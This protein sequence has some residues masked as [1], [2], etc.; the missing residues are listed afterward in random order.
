MIGKDLYITCRKIRK[1]QK[2]VLGNFVLVW[3]MTHSEIPGQ[4]VNTIP[5]SLKNTDSQSRGHS[6]RIPCSH[7]YLIEPGGKHS[8]IARWGYWLQLFHHECR[9][10][11][12]KSRNMETWMRWGPLCFRGA[13]IL[14]ERFWSNEEIPVGSNLM[15]GIRWL[16]SWRM[17]FEGSYTESCRI[18]PFC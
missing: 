4:N 11:R 16:M 7:I 5:S 2:S 1:A 15:S 17:E 13:D 12:E 6:P 10:K 3:H 14:A 9:E 18:Y 8:W